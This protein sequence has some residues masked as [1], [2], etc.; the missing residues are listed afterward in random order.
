M[1]L[2]RR[3]L[4]MRS[5]G[6]RSIRDLRGKLLVGAGGVLRLAS[7]AVPFGGSA[8]CSQLGAVI[9]LDLRR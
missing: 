7:S 5:E 4:H 9:C 1:P 6:R 3:I 2:G 8:V